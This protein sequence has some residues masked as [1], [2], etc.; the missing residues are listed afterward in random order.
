MIPNGIE[1]EPPPP[2]EPA[3]RARL[4]V[5]DG[6]PLVGSLGRLTWQ[7]APEVYA[8][9]CAILAC[10]HPDAH[11]VLVGSGPEEATVIGQVRRSALGDRFHRLPR[12]EDA[13]AAFGELDVFALASRFES[14]P[15]SVLEAMR[16]GVPVAATVADGTCDAVVPGTTGLLVPVDDP[17]ALAAATAGCSAIPPSGGP[18]GRPDG[19]G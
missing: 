4:G 7:K 8:S 15:Y 1:P 19:A 18:S 11:F 10:E 12:L 5:P 2:L 17:V 6:A 13:A 9:A 16:A 3:L 14:G